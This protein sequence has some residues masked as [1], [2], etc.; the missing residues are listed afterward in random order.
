[1]PMARCENVE[2]NKAALR[3]LPALLQRPEPEAVRR[4]FTPDF[5]LHDAKYPDWPRGHDG[6]LRMFLQMKTMMPD[7]DARIEDMFGEADKVFVRWRFKGVAT[8]N[9]EGRK[10][11]GSRIEVIVFAVYRFEDGKIAEDWGADIAL[12]PDHAWRTD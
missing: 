4:L 3:Q 1:M 6:A 5:R 9:F 2:R 10:G 8:G 7:L 12:P 11:D